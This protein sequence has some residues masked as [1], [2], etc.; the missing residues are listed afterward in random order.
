MFIVKCQC[1]TKLGREKS[2][3]LGILVFNIGYYE[4][5]TLQTY[6]LLNE[7]SRY[8]PEAQTHAS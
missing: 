3:D 7:N 6:V 5:A 8:C 2:G 4:S 1:R